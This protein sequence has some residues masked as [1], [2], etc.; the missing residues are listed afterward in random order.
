MRKSLTLAILIAVAFSGCLMPYQ[1]NF[2]CQADLNA[3]RCG[4]VRDNYKFSNENE[5][6]DFVYSFDENKTTQTKEKNTD[7]KTNCSQ[8]NGFKELIK[9][10]EENSKRYEYILIKKQRGE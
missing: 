3:G 10:H 7:M 4:M 6:K 9:C 1:E 5:Q 8:L 2:S